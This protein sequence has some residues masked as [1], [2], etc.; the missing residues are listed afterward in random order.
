MFYAHSSTVLY[1]IDPLTNALTEVGPFGGAFDPAGDQAT[2]LALNAAGELYIATY[3][4]IM[5][6]N[7]ETAEAELLSS[8]LGFTANALTFLPVDVGNPSGA[9][10]LVAGGSNQLMEINLVTGAATSIG[11][12]GPSAG[13]SGDLFYVRDVGIYAMLNAGQSSTSLA[14]LDA[15]TFA[16]TVIGPT[17]FSGVY[18]LA[19]YAG[20]FY[21]F[22]PAG[23]MFTI[24][25]TTGAGTLV[26]G[27]LPGVSFWGA[28]VSTTAPVEPIS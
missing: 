3:S 11:T 21:G 28:G 6:V 15:T 17:G 1:K 10:R 7:P 18:G 23:E 14:R 2:D 20:T 12:L 25:V 16:A 4:K 26:V 13:F 27:P 5:R 24:D 9:E 22:T 19:F 8:Q